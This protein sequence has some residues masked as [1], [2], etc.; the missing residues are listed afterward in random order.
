MTIQQESLPGDIWLV[1]ADGRLDQSQTTLL[2]TALNQLLD[3]GRVLIIVD[4][5]Q[6]SYINSGGLRCL[7]SAWRRAKQLDGD[8]LLCGLN[9]RLQEVFTMVGFDKV[10]QIHPTL[11]AAQRTLKKG[12]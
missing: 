10:F 6:A 8:V 12:R 9:D 4:L 5:S 3:D 1:R 2:E 11:A 7:V